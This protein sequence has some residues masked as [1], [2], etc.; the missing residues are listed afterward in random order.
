M[1]ITVRRAETGDNGRIIELLLQIA[2]VHHRGRPDIFKGGAKKY[3][4]DEFDAILE[5]PDRPVFVAADEGGS[6][7][8]YCFCMVVR[9]SAHAVFNDSSMLYIDDFCVDADCRGQ[10][11][12]HILFEE[13]KKY[14]RQIGVYLIDLNV[15]EFNEG[16]IKFY[17]S[18]G[19]TMQRR[20]MEMII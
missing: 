10:G 6:V 4:R 9:Y 8:G 2:D 5:D 12:G 1:G 14:A 18:C 20:R 11:I 19:F 16:A 3:G 13:V 17:E 15:W 7:L